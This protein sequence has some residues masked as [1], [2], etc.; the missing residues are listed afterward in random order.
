MSV[1]DAS[2][3]N[4]STV[5]EGDLIEVPKTD[6]DLAYCTLKGKQRVLDERWNY[7][8]GEQEE[9]FASEYFKNTF[10]STDV[11]ISENVCGVVA[12]AVTE[13]IRWLSFVVNGKAEQDDAATKALADLVKAIQLETEMID[14]HEAAVVMGEAYLIAWKNSDDDIQVD[15][16]DPRNCHMFADPDNPKK[17][18]FAAKWFVDMQKHRVIVLYYPERIEYWVSTSTI[19]TQSS[20]GKVEFVIDKEK[21]FPNPHKEIPV[22]GFRRRRPDVGKDTPTPEMD[23]AIP[24]QDEINKYAADGFLAA[25]YYGAPLRYAVT[26]NEG[27]KQLRRVPGEMLE[28]TPSDKEEHEPTQVGEFA[29]ADLMQLQD[30]LTAKIRTLATATN[31]PQHIFFGGQGT[32]SGDA[33]VALEAPLIHKV[34]D[35]TDRLTNQWVDAVNFLIT[36]SGATVEKDSIGVVWDDPGTVQPRTRA[37]IRKI[38]V[39][40]GIPL[41]VALKREGTWTEEELKEIENTLSPVTDVPPGQVA[42]SAEV[43]TGQA[44]GGLAPSVSDAVDLI[45]D[46]VVIAVSDGLKSLAKTFKAGNNTESEE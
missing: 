14:I 37:E 21:S 6:V 5:A 17:T 43:A 1:N 15:F 22:F 36:L 23:T 32:P 7:Y 19:K 45:G 11:R 34:R 28:F 10:G 8:R 35:W 25:E 18:L 4:A 26:N 2:S 42:A 29:A 20:Q 24:F 41:Q 33:L 39:E 16:Q 30:V 27:V 44:A 9:K 13:R 12:D 46:R 40:A 31:T 3:S 38:A